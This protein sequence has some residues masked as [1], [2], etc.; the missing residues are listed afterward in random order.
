[1]I[2]SVPQWIGVD[3]LSCRWQV[4]AARCCT[5][6]KHLTFYIKQHVFKT[7]SSGFMFWNLDDVCSPF[8]LTETLPFLPKRQT[9]IDD[10]RHLCSIVSISKL[11]P[12]KEIKT[13]KRSVTS[14]LT[15][16]DTN[17]SSWTRKSVKRSIHRCNI[18]HRAKK[19][20]ETNK[21]ANEQTKKYTICT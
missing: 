12:G 4:N 7:M 11:G 3:L 17:F 21:Q 1:M 18:K 2:S 10:R 19:E 5:I 20:K 13:I 8:H 14:L 6:D 16:F 15:S 9:S